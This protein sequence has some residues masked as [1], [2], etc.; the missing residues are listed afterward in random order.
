MASNIV[1]KF[2]KSSIATNESKKT[3]SVKP[4]EKHYGLHDDFI[5]I[6]GEKYMDDYIIEELYTISKMKNINVHIRARLCFMYMFAI[7]FNNECGYPL[8]NEP[9][10]YGGFCITLVMLCLGMNIPYDYTK[11]DLDI[12]LNNLKINEGHCSSIMMK[13]SEI[14][15][16]KSLGSN[17][18]S[19]SVKCISFEV[20]IFIDDKP[21]TFNIDIT[22]INDYNISPIFDVNTL[23]VSLHTHMIFNIAKEFQQ[24]FSKIDISF[25]TSLFHTFIHKK[26]ARDKYDTVIN[27]LKNIQSRITKVVNPF[28]FTANNSTL[29]VK[30]ISKI[31]NKQFVIDS[32][33]PQL[34]RYKES[35]INNTHDTNCSIC[36]TTIYDDETLPD[37]LKETQ[38]VLTCGHHFHPTCLTE[39]VN[40]KI[41]DDYGERLNTKCPLCRVEIYLKLTI[42]GKTS[43]EDFNKI[44]TDIKKLF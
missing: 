25:L 8:P 27:I 37:F 41:Y 39:L 13:L 34:L 11:Q 40:T 12:C 6:L 36:L 9:Y 42:I 18:M 17:N 2:I 22:K 3:D 38:M 19:S 7:I 35:D 20:E 33:I 16:I 1:S 4:D 28:I 32:K 15:K 24:N 26:R 21:I 10:I 5:K 14:M 44:V 43:D 29:I 31:Y 23:A 30:R